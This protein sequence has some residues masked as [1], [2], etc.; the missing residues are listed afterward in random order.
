[1]NAFIKYFWIF[2]IGSS[3][4]FICETLWCIIKNKKIESRK[5]LIYGHYIPIYGITGVLMTFFIETFDV[6]NKVMLFLITF[7]ISS[8]VEYLSSYFQ[9]KVFK[10]VSWDYSDMKYSVNGRINLIYSFMWG[11]LGIVWYQLYPILLNTILIFLRNFDMLMETTLIWGFYMSYNIII[12]AM[13]SYRQ[14]NRREGK[15]ANNVLDNWLDKK[16]N[17]QVLAKIYVNAKEVV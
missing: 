13:A 14:R 16:Y 15:I 3:L 9:E 4:G 1:M 12:S 11:F 6:K 5:G 8:L 10:T 2:M 7:A 17:D